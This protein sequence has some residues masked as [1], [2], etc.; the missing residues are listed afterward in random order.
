MRLRFLRT[1]IHHP[2]AGQSGW[3]QLFTHA[4]H[5]T[6]S[7]AL[8]DTLASVC[9]CLRLGVGR[10]VYRCVCCRVPLSRSS[11]RVRTTLLCNLVFGPQCVFVMSRKCNNVEFDSSLSSKQEAAAVRDEERRA[12]CC[13]LVFWTFSCSTSRCRK[14]SGC[15]LNDTKCIRLFP[16][17]LSRSQRRNEEVLLEKIMCSLTVA[18]RSSKLGIVSWPRPYQKHITFVRRLHSRY[19]TA[20]LITA[21]LT[22]LTIT[23]L[24]SQCAERGMPPITIWAL[25]GRCLCHSIHRFNGSRSH[26]RQTAGTFER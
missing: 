15:H 2:D 10:L 3:D 14:S 9:V 19:A 20:S 5:Q 23:Q 13:F 22:A 17:E 6:S 11:G 1:L 16:S 18:Q 26:G 21:L 4:G 25:K 12:E 8:N 24:I 7:Q